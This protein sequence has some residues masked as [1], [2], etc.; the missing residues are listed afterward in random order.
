MS[1]RSLT[2]WSAFHSGKPPPFCLFP[3]I[4]A[5]LGPGERGGRRF[6]G[7]FNSRETC[8]YTVRKRRREGKLGRPY[9][10]NASTLVHKRPCGKP[11]CSAERLGAIDVQGCPQ[12]VLPFNLGKELPQLRLRSPQSSSLIHVRALLSKR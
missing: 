5:D 9:H 4:T 11:A 10:Q 8:K 6:R 2:N 12:L 1:F 3:W 7:R